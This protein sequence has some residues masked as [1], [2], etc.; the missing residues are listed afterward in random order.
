MQGLLY[1]KSQIANLRHEDMNIILIS[2]KILYAVFF[3]LGGLHG[4]REVPRHQFVNP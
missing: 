3:M 2:V 1:L 4:T